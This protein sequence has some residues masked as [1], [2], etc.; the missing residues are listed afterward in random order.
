MVYDLYWDSGYGNARYPGSWGILQTPAITVPAGVTTVQ[1]LIVMN[2]GG[3]YRFHRA[4]L[5]KVPAGT[6][7]L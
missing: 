2:G 7:A 5:R 6:T 1:V 4:A 3:N